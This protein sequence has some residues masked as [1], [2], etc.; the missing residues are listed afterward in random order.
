MAALIAPD[1]ARRLV[2]RL[3]EPRVAAAVAAVAIAALGVA[4]T[5]VGTEAI[6]NQG[7][8]SHSPFHL[9]NERTIPAFFS[10]ALLGAGALLA[11]LAARL[12]PRGERLSWTVFGL[13]LLL[14]SA[15]EVAEIH[16]RLE[17]WTGTDWQQ[18]YLPVAALAAVAWWRIVKHVRGA[19]RVMLVAG[20]VA[21]TIAF[22]LEDAQYDS[23]DR[24]VD[25]FE[26]MAITEEVLEMA[27]SALFGLALLT[28]LRAAHARRPQ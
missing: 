26:P 18:I 22:G 7:P 27:G 17:T 20:A 2:E 16:E 12:E 11:F 13:V 5:V 8:V 19:A 10:G 25:L 24:R 9:I 28:A 4:G 15:D 6:P 21:W 1:T 23:R 3:P 14:M